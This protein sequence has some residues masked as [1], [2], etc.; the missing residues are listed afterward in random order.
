MDNSEKYSEKNFEHWLAMFTVH[1]KNWMDENI[2]EQISLYKQM[3]GDEE[4]RNLQK[5]V[6]GIVINNDLGYFLVK[7]YKDSFLKI[8]DLDRMTKIILEND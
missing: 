5:E 4:Y 6:K 1:Q 7:K 8:D 2:F 3:E